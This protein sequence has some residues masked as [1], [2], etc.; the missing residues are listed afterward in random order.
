MDKFIAM[1]KSSAF[2][3]N[4]DQSTD[5]E[6]SDV[7][8]KDSDAIANSTFKW[9]L[10]SYENT[11]KKGLNCHIAQMHEEKQKLG[12]TSAIPQLDG[13]SYSEQNDF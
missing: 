6:T 9:D 13:T 5:K 4:S 3:A 7:I 2:T 8:L 10:C 1:K 12:N 11:T